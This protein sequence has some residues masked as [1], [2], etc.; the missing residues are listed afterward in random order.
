MNLT[1]PENSSLHAAMKPWP[2]KQPKQPARSAGHLSD[3]WVG[4]DGAAE[5]PRVVHRGGGALA[6]LS[7]AQWLGSSSTAAGGARSCV[8]RRAPMRRSVSVSST[9]S[10]AMVALQPEGLGESGGGG[11]MQANHRARRNRRRSAA[12]PSSF[13]S[14]ELSLRLPDPSASREPRSG[15]RH[16]KF[17]C[18]AG[19]SCCTARV[20]ERTYVP[21]YLGNNYQLQY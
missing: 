13:A 5:P 1:Q 6:G 16:P 21:W 3:G 11:P 2:Q 9:A 14:S 17:R 20:H 10:S 19:Y 4:G 15:M 7:H 12:T 8:L 18:M